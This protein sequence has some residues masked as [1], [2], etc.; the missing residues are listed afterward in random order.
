[1]IFED[2]CDEPEPEDENEEPKTCPLCNSY[3]AFMGSLGKLDWYRC[4]G[5]G[6][7]FN[8]ETTS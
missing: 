4:T 1:M 6:I 5:C 3:A 7:E 8:I 2:Y